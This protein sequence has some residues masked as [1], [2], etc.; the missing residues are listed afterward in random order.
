MELCDLNSLCQTDCRQSRIVL[1]MKNFILD[2]PKA[3]VMVV[4]CVN[5]VAHASITFDFVL[6]AAVEQRPSLRP[7]ATVH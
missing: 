6:S 5:D 2:L 1:G 4:D 7:L 3:N